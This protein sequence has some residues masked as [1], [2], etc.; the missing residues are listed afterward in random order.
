LKPVDAETVEIAGEEEA[1]RGG[2]QEGD[3][4]RQRVEKPGP[5]WVPGAARGGE[6]MAGEETAMCAVREGR[7]CVEGKTERH[8]T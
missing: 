5:R 6:A 8:R 1:E 3:G 4:E 2:Y 7:S